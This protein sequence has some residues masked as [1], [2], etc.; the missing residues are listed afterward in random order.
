[1]STAFIAAASAYTGRWREGAPGYRHRL[2]APSRSENSLMSETV[3]HS[4]DDVVAFLKDQHDE[5]KRLF[6]ETLNA[7]DAESREKLFFELRRLLAVHEAAEVVVVV[8]VHPLARRTIAFGQGIADA[9]L[10]EEKEAKKQLAGIEKMDATQ[11]NSFKRSRGC[12]RRCWSTPVMKRP[13]SSASCKRTLIKATSSVPPPWS[14]RRAY[15]TD[16][17]PSRCEF[18]NG[19][20]RR[21]PIRGHAGPCP[22]RTE[23]DRV[24]PTE[25]LAFLDGRPLQHTDRNESFENTGLL[26]PLD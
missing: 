12:S 19:E 18:G 14:D 23:G 13:K 10:S 24:E 20:H 15:R 6:A 5:I 17:A 22:R 16:P 21:G 8:V 26:I 9:R 11:R 4:A 25:T 1:V 7:T 2:P 3:V